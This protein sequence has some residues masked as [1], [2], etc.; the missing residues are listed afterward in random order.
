MEPALGNIAYQPKSTVENEE[1]MNSQ[2]ANSH[3]VETVRRTN[4]RTMK[5]I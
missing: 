4:Q 5:E 1:N 3:A 2:Q